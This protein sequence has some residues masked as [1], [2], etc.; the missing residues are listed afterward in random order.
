MSLKI[1][2]VSRMNAD[3]ERWVSLVDYLHDKMEVHMFHAKDIERLENPSM[4]AILDECGVEIQEYADLCFFHRIFLRL[5][6]FARNYS[7]SVIWRLGQIF[8]EIGQRQLKTKIYNYL[9]KL[10]PEVLFITPYLNMENSGYEALSHSH[11]WFVENNRFIIS[12]DHGSMIYAPK[13]SLIEI[14]NFIHAFFSSSEVCAKRVVGRDLK[15]P[16]INIGDVKNSITFIR[17]LKSYFRKICHGRTVALFMPADI[18]ANLK[19]WNFALQMVDK[20]RNY[21]EID[22]IIVKAH[23]NS[24]YLPF[25]KAL[26]K[27]PKVKFIYTEYNSCEICLEADIVICHPSSVLIDAL[28]LDTAVYLVDSKSDWDIIH[29]YRELELTALKPKEWLE[30]ENIFDLPFKFN[31]NAFRKY[32]YNDAPD[33]ENRE[34]VYQFLQ[35]HCGSHLSLSVEDL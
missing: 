13:S 19:H 29:S 17:K 1:L 11:D 9:D 23:P 33:G 6:A 28:S 21:D 27:D 7:S 18:N 35:D 15:N 4:H 24:T 32:A 26:P 12:A 25:S 22:N 5:N 8:R 34:L 31:R 2:F 3:F 20:L 30:L 10:N 14:N 16:A